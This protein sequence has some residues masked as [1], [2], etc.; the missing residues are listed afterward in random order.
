MLLNILMHTVDY[1]SVNVHDW[2]NIICAILT[3]HLQTLCQFYKYEL[4]QTLV[5]SCHKRYFPDVPRGGI[6]R[7]WD[8][9]FKPLYTLKRALS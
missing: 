2:I 8:F 7:P 5:L 4:V 9:T 3:L 6:F 1:H